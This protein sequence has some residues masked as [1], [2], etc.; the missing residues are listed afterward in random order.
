MNILGF[1]YPDTHY[2]WLERDMWCLPQADGLIKVGVSQFGVHISGDFYMCR[3]KKAGTHLLQGETLGVV[4]LSKSVVAIKTPVSGEV[5]EVNPLLE[6]TPERVHQDCFGDGWLVLIAPS[7][8]SKDLTQLHHGP[9]LL[10]A[11]E[12]R[13]RLEPM[14]FPSNTPPPT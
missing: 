3:P 2:F 9:S 4:E 8:W 11:A 6:E 12:R 13:M 5:V 7:R 1:E 14:S 10:E